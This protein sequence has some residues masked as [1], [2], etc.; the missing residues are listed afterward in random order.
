[1]LDFVAMPDPFLTRLQERAASEKKRIALPESTEPRTL[2]A[3]IAMKQR[4]VAE[5]VLIGDAEAIAEA[6]QATGV[7]RAQLAG[8]EIRSANDSKDACADVYADALYQRGRH[9]G[10]SEDEA[11]TQAR[12]PSVLRRAHG[13]CRGCLG[14][15]RG[16]RE[17]HG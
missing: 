16:R 5:P 6:A 15:R 14:L 10:I 1:M 12:D 4:G 11:R 9:K 8:I 7:T 13:V 2:E 17:Q 3:A